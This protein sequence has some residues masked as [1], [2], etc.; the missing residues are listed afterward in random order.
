MIDPHIWRLDEEDGGVGLSCSNAGLFLGTTP[1]LHLHPDGFVPRPQAELERLLSRGFGSGVVLDR[2]MPGLGGVA[3]ALNDN[4]LCRA[5]IAAVQLRLP[6]LPDTLARLAMETEDLLIKVEAR[7]NH[8]GPGGWDPT[9][10]PRA[11]TAPNPGWFAPKDSVSGDAD[12]KALH[13]PPGD[14]NE[15]IGDL[16][17]WI[18]NAKP[19]DVQP[20]SEE[21]S[22]IFY[23]NSDFAD[24]A[25]FHQALVESLADPDTANRQRILDQYEPITHK[26]PSGVGQVVTDIGVAT[27]LAPL[28]SGARALGSAA[29]LA[30]SAEVATEAASRFW[31]LGWAARGAAIHKAM[32]GNLPFAFKTIDD[33]T[34][35]IATSIKSIDLNAA[36]YQDASRLGYRLNDYIKKL[37]TFKDTEYGGYVVRSAEIDQRVLH[38]VVPKGSMT[39][40]QKGAMDA[41]TE[42]AKNAGI[43]LKI[44]EF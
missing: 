34:D 16:L 24:G 13:L 33:F 2:V 41:A 1:L 20:I 35:G 29:E 17:E 8:E 9:Q 18:A 14:R 11:G 22:R 12:D 6:E 4:N 28:F 3:S 38:V 21:I 25:M 32:G 37:A 42:G 44:T 39:A 19:E 31:G 26:D 23:Q 27:A 40:V 15:E 30:P 10:H 43:T 36:T 5:R 7:S